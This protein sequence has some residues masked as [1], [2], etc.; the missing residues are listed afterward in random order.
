MLQEKFLRRSLT[1][2]F[3]V[4]AVQRTGQW[5]RSRRCDDQGGTVGQQVCR[6]WTKGLDDQRAS[7]RLW[8]SGP[9]NLDVP[10]HDGLSYFI[11]DMRQ[12]GVEV[13][14]LRQMNH[15]ASF[16]QVF[17]TDAEVPPVSPGERR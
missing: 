8:P 12:P 17:M 6:E 16:N 3:L 2:E 5:V 4:P 13:V 10:K 7:C 11:M 14:P 15:H 9:D 1:G